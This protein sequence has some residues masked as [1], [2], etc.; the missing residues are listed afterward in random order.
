MQLKRDSTK[1]EYW[2]CAACG[3]EFKYGLGAGWLEP[4][5]QDKD[6]QHIIFMQIP[7]GDGAT[8]TMCARAVEPTNAQDA[9]ILALKGITAAAGLSVPAGA[10]AGLI[11]LVTDANKCSEHMVGD[12]F[13]RAT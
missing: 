8:R 13:P 1:R 2:F 12:K 9:C 6:Y 10:K 4:R 3:G 5:G 7:W 11:A